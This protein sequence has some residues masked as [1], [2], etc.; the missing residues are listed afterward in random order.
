MKAKGYDGVTIEGGWILNDK[1]REMK[2]EIIDK[3]GNLIL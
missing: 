2:L 1:E 3:E